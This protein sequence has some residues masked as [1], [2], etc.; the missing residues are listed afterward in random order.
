MTRQP[1]EG[2]QTDHP[3]EAAPPALE[4]SGLSV[5]YGTRRVTDAL[6]L[7]IAT[8]E[9]FGLLGPNGS[10]KTTL[11]RAIC[12]RLKP[13]AGRIRI[14]GE[15]NT[16]R[17]ALRRVGLVPQEIA[18]YPH[19]TARE[20]LVTF[21]R[22]SGLSHQQA[23]SAL[24]F[25]VEATRL[26]KH[27]DD[28]VHTLSGGWKRRANIAAALLHG[29]SL[30]ILDEPTVGVDIDA[31]NALHTVIRNL[32]RSGLA[33]LLTTHDL[34]QAQ[35]LCGR[36]GFLRDGKVSPVGRPVDLLKDAFGT[37]CELLV[38]LYEPARTATRD[39][40]KRLGFASRQLGLEW[41][42]MIDASPEAQAGLT[43]ALHRTDLRIKE[44]RFREPDLDSLF[45]RLTGEDTPS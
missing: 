30:L 17:R 1:T 26:T 8:S 28:A 15:Q 37:R 41:S 42:R 7:T 45:T 43:D 23:M 24:D 13:A 22:L 34:D 21:G 16:K 14:A 29:P 9:I 25:A 44:I 27:L 3:L 6:D 12:R 4:I 19:L 2:T 11:V 31:R 39:M 40:L 10:G 5:R 35:A 36:V 32:G 33:V 18:L 20:N 38:D